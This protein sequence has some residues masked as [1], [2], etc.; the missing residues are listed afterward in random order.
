MKQ[1]VSRCT[2]TRSGTSLDHLKNFKM[3]EENFRKEVELMN[4]A[5][6]VETA[7][8]YN[9]SLDYAIPKTGAKMDWADVEDD[10]FTI[11]LNG[12]KRISYS[13]VYSLSQGEITIDGENE[14][15][16]TI[17]FAAASKDMD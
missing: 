2:V 12:G 9:F 3:N 13:G 16:I 5:G 1:Y 14:A 4:G 17:N 11:E 7:R 15:V 6:T 10:T 8:R